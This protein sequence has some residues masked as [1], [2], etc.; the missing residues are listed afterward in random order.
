MVT[1]S[2]LAKKNMFIYIFKCNMQ[3][4][5]LTKEGENGMVKYLPESFDSNMRRFE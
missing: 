4:V 5:I 2:F 3:I 1:F